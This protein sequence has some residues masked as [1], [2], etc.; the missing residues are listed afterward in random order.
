VKETWHKLISI[1]HSLTLVLSFM[2]RGHNLMLI[3]Y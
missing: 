2:G 1:C 3:F